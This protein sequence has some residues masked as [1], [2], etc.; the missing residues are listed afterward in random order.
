[1]MQL[2]LGGRRTTVYVPARRDEMLRFF[3]ARILG[4]LPRFRWGLFQEAVRAKNYQR[5]L[6]IAA[7]A[8]DEEAERYAV[9]KT[10]FGSS[11]V[12]VSAP[13]RVPLY[14]ASIFGRLDVID[15]V[16]ALERFALDEAKRPYDGAEGET[17]RIRYDRNAA[18]AVE[19]HDSRL[20]QALEHKADY[21]R[22]AAILSAVRQRPG[23]LQVDLTEVVTDRDTKGVTRMVDQLEATDLV[24]TKKVG[25]RVGVWPAEHPKGPSPSDRREQRWYWAVDDYWEERP[26]EWLDLSATISGIET[27][28]RTVEEAARQTGIDG[29]LRPTPLDFIQGSKWHFASPAMSGGIPTHEDPDQL[30]MVFWGHHDLTQAAAMAG[31]I[32]HD[33]G[34]QTTANQKKKWLLAEPR[35]THMERMSFTEGFSLD[36]SRHTGWLLREVPEPTADSVPATAFTAAGVCTDQEKAAELGVACWL[37][38]SKVRAPRPA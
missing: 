5:A 10:M 27:L 31:R 36:T 12:N 9:R 33:G 25:S 30:A 37:K 17:G 4:D 20:E 3:R 34:A 32:I 29:G 21:E 7:Q 28:A 38:R 23:V 8:L 13:D 19:T 24:A 16:I 2:D 6:D 11:H 14:L 35:H 1:M 22:F 18:F 26:F 15:R